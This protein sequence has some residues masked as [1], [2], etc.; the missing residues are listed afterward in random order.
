[1]S[2]TEAVAETSTEAVLSQLERQLSAARL[3]EAQTF[4]QQFL[5]RVPRHDLAA[6]SAAD[7]AAIALGALEFARERR[8]GS[9]KIRVFNPAAAEHGYDSPHSVVE[10]VTDD[11]PFLVDSVS[12]ALAQEG[13]ALHAVIH[14]VYAIERDPGGHILHLAAE[15]GRGKVESV[16]HFEID[17][18]ADA[19]ELE[20]LKQAIAAALDDV[21]ACVADWRQMREKMLEIADALAGGSAP[22]D[23]D[24]LAEGR[25]FLHWVADDHFTFLGYREY[26]VAE[27]GG[28]EVLVAVDGSG[29]GILRGSERSVA[30]RSLKTLVAKELPQSGSVD[31]IILTKTNAR[32]RVHRPGY[33]DYIG[34]LGFD[35]AGVPVVEHRFLGQF[36]S[37]AYMARP[38]DVPLVRRKVE[39]VVA[40]SGLR[41]D[42]HSGKALRHILNTLPR[43]ELFQCSEDELYPIAMGILDLQERARTRLFVRA[44][45]YARFYSCLVFLP[46]ERFDSDVRN[47][48]E[49][50]LKRA[51][52]GERTDS[53]IEVGESP[54]ARIHLVVRPKPG[55][56]P[57]YDVAE[58]EGRINQIVRNWHD[59]L[60][61][62]LVQRHGEERASSSRTAT[63]RRCRW[64][65][66]RR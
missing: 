13:L 51:F 21:R 3:R 58:L 4:A 55:D 61:D 64:A 20:R 44:D 35:A 29:L 43:D 56:R 34:V 17:R 39:S 49:T 31:A 6:R 25:E 60:R 59:E 10:I 54:L 8:A 30:P 22:V 1:M 62:I 9:V 65:T 47:R 18:I 32:S 52:R 15:G 5:A 37:A 27:A 45:R 63:A 7:W 23:S 14:P 66:S 33:M 57:S 48:I 16:M 53:A 12:M 24:G 40:R 38:Q 2:A 42:A 50:L 41:R 28:D 26:R 36:S 11:M 19:G 46:R